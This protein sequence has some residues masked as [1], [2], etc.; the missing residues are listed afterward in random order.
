MLLRAHHS[1]AARRPPRAATAHAAAACADTHARRDGVRQTP[2]G[3][4]CRRRFGGGAQNQVVKALAQLFRLRLVRE[5]EPGA[6]PSER[7]WHLLR[8]K[9]WRGGPGAPPTPAARK[10]CA[11]LLA[12]DDGLKGVRRKQHAARAAAWAVAAAPA[13]AAAKC[14]ADRGAGAGG[15]AH[16][17]SVADTR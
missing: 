14:F 13:P 15:G 6:P 1:R 3:W 4:T 7:P 10:L 8:P 12:G 17:P 16:L 9:R 5:G 2:R 11:A